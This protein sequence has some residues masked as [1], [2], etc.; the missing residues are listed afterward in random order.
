MRLHY[1][2]GEHLVGTRI[3][4]N[5]LNSLIGLHA[6]RCSAAI[7]YTLIETTKLNCVDPQAWLTD[8]L[9]RS[10]TK[11]STNCCLANTIDSAEHFLVLAFCSLIAERTRECRCEVRL[12]REMP[13]RHLID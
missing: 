10:L 13:R 9:A 7:A 1:Q 6:D 2:V 11:R 3:G 4:R 5:R 12:A 8:I